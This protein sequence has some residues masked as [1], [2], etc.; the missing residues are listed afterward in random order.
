M[1]PLYIYS[2]KNIYIIGRKLL[3]I[4]VP[5]KNKYTSKRDISTKINEK[6]VFKKISTILFPKSTL[7]SEIGRSASPLLAHAPHEKSPALYG[8]MLA[9]A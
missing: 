9:N 5:P 8:Y 3:G 2:Y 6:N 1:L 4:L 7:L